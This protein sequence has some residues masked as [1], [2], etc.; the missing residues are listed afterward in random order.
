MIVVTA[1]PVVNAK[2]R[3]ITTKIVFITLALC[4]NLSMAEPA[5]RSVIGITEHRF[6][7]NIGG[8]PRVVGSAVKYLFS[9]MFLFYP[10]LRWRA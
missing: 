8:A 4:S 9:L 1:M 5:G 3:T 10:A 6:S 2:A 7:T